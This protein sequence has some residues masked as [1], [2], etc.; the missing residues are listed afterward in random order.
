MGMPM[1]CNL[2][3]GGHAVTG[4][5]PSEQA[6][7]RFASAGGRLADSERA[8]CRCE[9]ILM[10]LPHST[11]LTRLAD[12]VLLPEARKGQ[13]FVDFT[14]VVPREV[15]RLAIEF[16][17]H[18][19][20]YLDCPVTGGPQGVIDRLLR[21][22]AGGDPEAFA[23]VRPLLDTVTAPTEVHYCGES[24]NGQVVKGVNQ[25]GMGLVEAAAIEAVAYGV[26]SGIPPEMLGKAVGGDDGFRILIRSFADRV[27]KLAGGG[28]SIKYDQFEFFLDEAANRGFSLPIVAHLQELLAN[29]PKTVRAAN[30]D[31]PSYWD[32]LAARFPN[33]P[34]D[35]E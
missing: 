14:T 16:A 20:H 19:A 34:E 32:F 31:G 29:E 9:V 28:A 7:A 25:I 5:D 26:A 30:Q 17:G 15:R 10:S 6:R 4:W 27:A 33:S 13:V 12:E 3:E 1:A 24:G 35:S 11:V 8:V 23:A 22:Y 2:L 18:G 21:I